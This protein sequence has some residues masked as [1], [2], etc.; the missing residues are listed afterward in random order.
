M[1]LLSLGDQFL[2]TN[3][4]FRL[5]AVK[6]KFLKVQGD[7]GRV[8]TLTFLQ[9]FSSSGINLLSESSLISEKRVISWVC[10]IYFTMLYQR[11]CPPLI[12]VFGKNGT[13][14][15]IFIL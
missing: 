15:K 4:G 7:L 2:T 14:I 5:K 1:A 10:D 6:N 11:V 12:E 13:S 9:Y 8:N 3:N